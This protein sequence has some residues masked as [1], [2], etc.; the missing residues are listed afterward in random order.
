MKTPRLFPMSSSRIAL[1]ILVVLLVLASNSACHRPEPAIPDTSVELSADWHIASSAVIEPNGEMI[2]QNGFDTSGWTA[3]TV[4]T[5]VLAALVE[6]GEIDNPYYNQTLER[7][8]TERFAVPWWFRTEFA[9]ASPPPAS[10]RLVFDGLNYSG[11]VWLNGNL[12]ATNADVAGAF[13]VFELEVGQYLTAGANTLAIAVS[14]PRPGDPTIGFVDWNPTA[15]DRNMGLWRGVSLRWTSGVSIDDVAVRT[16]LDPAALDRASLTIQMHLANRSD[17][18]LVATLS[19]TIRPSDSDHPAGSSIELDHEIELG[20]GESLDLVLSPAELPQLVIE[21]PRLW[22][23][24]DLGEPNLYQLELVARVGGAAQDH[25]EV[26]F[27]IRH[28]A[29]YMTD[30]GHRGYEIN[31]EKLLIRGG[32][33]VDDLMLNDDD[34]KVE[35]QVL[36]A[37][38]LGLNTI[39]LEG[40]WGSSHHLYDLADRYGM[41]I[42]VGWSCQWEWEEYLG[43]PVDKFGGIDTPEE[44]RLVAESLSDQVVYLRNHPSIFLWVLAS[45][46]LPRPELE[47]RYAEELAI[48]DPTRPTLAA[49]SVR[50]SEVSGPTGVKMNGPYDYV[51]PS[52]WYLD[53]KRGGAFGFNTETGPGPQPPP[54]ESIQRMLPEEHWWPIDEMWNYHCG[55]HEF[56]TLDRYQQALTARYGKADSL[57][58]FATKS[59]VASYEA[60]RAMFEAFSVRRPAT[61]GIV[62]W[63]L[64]SAWPEMYWQLYDYYLVPNG[65]YFGARLANR[66]IHVIYD[67]GNRRLVAINDTNSAL[68][69]VTAHLR[70]FDTASELVHEERITVGAVAKKSRVEISTLPEISTQGVYFV[71]IELVGSAGQ[72]LASNFYW[73]TAQSDVLDWEASTWFTT[74]Q[75]KFAD[76]SAVANLPEAA[77]DVDHIF[78]PKDG[79][80]EL[81][82]SLA[83][84]TE[85]LAFFVELRVVTGESGRSLVAPILWD[86][87]YISLI[88]GEKREV[89]AT[90]PDHA[91]AG[92]EPVFRYRGLNVKQSR[93]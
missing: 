86:D 64:N 65:A 56:N 85:Q 87:N 42:M 52:Y 41:L 26:T 90:F 15:P 20:A 72:V 81:R 44:Q 88:P 92:G 3:A 37:R 1:A 59:Q 17:R 6:A 34:Q 58:D 16:E 82:V 23:P 14:P 76:L 93:K 38:H 49:C 55:R 5:T 46:M 11:E 22:W 66:P 51:P 28:V 13:R 83:N 60:M 69:D 91:L 74:P 10:A 24:H 61:T 31:G 89:R 35:D 43:G 7:I 54:L 71:D 40:F 39:R 47:K 19:G 45:D 84:D 25:Q 70:V 32:G 78:E 50:T 68:G 77:I 9:L 2:S 30:E 12:I 18:P 67:Y 79:H 36:Y 63:M 80:T 4:P 29:D 53:D 33:W 8:P 48:A 57:E 62:Q 27:G 73:L 75:S 21:N